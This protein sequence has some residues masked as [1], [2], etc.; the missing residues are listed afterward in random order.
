MNNIKFKNK[1]FKYKTKYLNLIK[2]NNNRKRKIISVALKKTFS[3]LQQGGG[4]GTAKD[5][6]E[7]TKLLELFSFLIICP[8]TQEIIVDPVILSDGQTYE[9]EAITQWLRTSSKS[10]ITGLPLDNRT[11]IPNIALKNIIENIVEQ[12][13]VS[14]HDIQEYYESKGIEGSQLIKKKRLV[15]KNKI[16]NSKL[17]LFD[18][19]KFL[20]ITAINVN[21]EFQNPNSLIKSINIIYNCKKYIR[22]S[23]KADIRDG[24]ILSSYYYDKESITLKDLDFTFENHIRI[25]NHDLIDELSIIDNPSGDEIIEI[26][27]LLNDNLLDKT[28]FFK[29]IQD[30]Q[31][32]KVRISPRLKYNPTIYSFI[33]PAKRSPI[34]DKILTNLANSEIPIINFNELGDIVNPMHIH[35]NALDGLDGDNMLRDS[36]EERK[37]KMIHH[38]KELNGKL[39]HTFYTQYG[40]L[41]EDI[42]ED[43]TDELVPGEKIIVD[44]TS[45][46]IAFTGDK[47]VGKTYLT[48][49]IIKPEHIFETD[50]TSKENFIRDYNS[51][52][53]IVV[54]QRD[55]TFNLDYIKTVIGKSKQIYECRIVNLSDKINKEEALRMEQIKKEQEEERLRQE[56]ES[57]KEVIAMHKTHEENILKE[58]QKF[59]PDFKPAENDI[60]VIAYREKFEPVDVEGNEK[61]D[62]YYYLY[63][64]DGD[65][66]ILS[67][68]N[69]MCRSG[70]LTATFA[71]VE[72][73]PS[74]WYNNEEFETVRENR[75]KSPLQ[76]LGFEKHGTA[77]DYTLYFSNDTNI[78]VTYNGGDDYYPSGYIDFNLT[79]GDEFQTVDLEEDQVD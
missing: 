66:I 55:P 68:T 65:T 52:Q 42:L 21:Y 70:Y 25:T 41:M 46:L 40:I 50:S 27:E 39:G 19:D 37:G 9:R 34:F 38:I 76:Y 57:M 6:V 63:L 11:L 24:K 45:F 10:P 16:K 35:I 1:Y 23:Y 14:L 61:I 17:K 60:Y 73:I 26:F 43:G 28:N 4:G 51:Q 72:F 2:D 58:I 64:S 47:G 32:D 15:I 56:E 69:G 54:G 30:G 78:Y 67:N 75:L 36:E 20:K 31:L 77:S 5:L 22:I 48:Q 12:G 13:L 7:T 29:V 74:F 3:Y 44:T 59:M 49:K 79:D 18:E 53:V 33:L 8:I 62:E 71:E